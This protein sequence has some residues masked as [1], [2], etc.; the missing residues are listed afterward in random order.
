MLAR[1]LGV[2][3][4]EIRRRNVL[5]PE[6]LPHKLEVIG[7]WAEKEQ[8]DTSDLVLSNELKGR[9]EQGARA[10]FDAGVRLFTLGVSGPEIDF[11]AVGRWL[12]WRDGLNG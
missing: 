2:D 10:L 12:T 5:T 1:E 4:A 11:D 8:R 9:D 7:R 3:R 6:D